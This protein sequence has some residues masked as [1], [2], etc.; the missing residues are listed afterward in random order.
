MARILVLYEAE[1]L[2]HPPPA[3]EVIGHGAA[4]VAGTYVRM[5]SLDDAGAADLRWCD[6][7]AVEATDSRGRLPERMK[8]WWDHL[9]F[10]AWDN[11]L[12]GKCGCTFQ[13]ARPRDEASL[14]G[15]RALDALLQRRGIAVV[16]SEA[17]GSPS[18]PVPQRQPDH[19]GD[20][21]RRVRQLGHL[22]AE[23][24]GARADGHVEQRSGGFPAAAL[25]A[26][27]R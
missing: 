6:G 27:T 24:A 26:R 8:Q 9:G 21:Y 20:P 15:A 7:V 10:H 18:V 12:T 5:R 4:S 23:Y 25:G 2:G 3:A 11:S 16:G 17:A 22:L 13:A 14:A 19:A 1:A